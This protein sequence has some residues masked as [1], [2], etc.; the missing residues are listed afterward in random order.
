M[1]SKSYCPFCTKTKSTLSS[2][3]PALGLT[4]PPLIIE[5]DER[6]DGANIQTTLQTMSGQRT[7]PNVYVKGVHVGGNDDFQKAV[8]NGKVKEIIEG[9][10]DL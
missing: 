10:K 3:A 2:Y 4:A 8:A 9:A 5:L 6:P 1:F 7:V